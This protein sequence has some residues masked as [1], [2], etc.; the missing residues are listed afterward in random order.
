M[1]SGSA[2]LIVLGPWLFAVSIAIYPK[3]PI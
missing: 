1:G 3:S 2:E